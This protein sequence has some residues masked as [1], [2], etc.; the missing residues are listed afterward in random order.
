MKCDFLIDFDDKND[1]KCVPL[2]QIIA[3]VNVFHVVCMIV[4][5]SKVLNNFNFC[6]VSKTNG[7]GKLDIII[8]GHKLK[9]ESKLLDKY[10]VIKTFVFYLNSI[11]S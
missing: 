4:G 6:L 10:F 3:K 11:V 7:S 8:L 2:L 9:L 5:F 1:K